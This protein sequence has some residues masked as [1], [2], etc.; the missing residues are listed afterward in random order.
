[1]LERQP[2]HDLLNVD[3]VE[4][5]TDLLITANKQTFFKFKNN[6]F[7]MRDGL[8]MG[9]PLAG[10]MSDVFIHNN[11][12]IELF[13]EKYKSINEHITF[14]YRYVDDIII[15]FSGTNA[16][17][18]ALHTILNNLSNLQFTLEKENNHNIQFLDLT[19]SRN[20]INN[21]LNF[22]IFRKPTHTDVIIPKSSFNS[23]QNK[24]ASFRFFFNRINNIPLSKQDYNTEILNIMNIGIKNGYSLKEM[25]KIYDKLHRKSINNV[26]YPHICEKPQF[27][28]LKFLGKISYDI[29]N[30]LHKYNVNVVFRTNTKLGALMSNTKQKHNRLGKSGIYKIACDDCNCFYIGQT[31]KNLE[32]RFKQ[33][34]KDRNSSVFKHLQQNKHT[35]NNNNIQLLHECCKSR[36]MNILED[37]EIIKHHREAPDLILNEHTT[38]NDRHLCIEMLG[39]A[40][41]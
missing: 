31:G 21:T 22:N 3:D 1:M 12:E 18:V 8:A 15:L 24:L 27:M 6:F 35:T 20:T 28:S 39:S 36:R 29:K 38:F 17:I 34:L 37:Y 16:H 7:H 26:I 41:R 19:I 4:N 32:T 5:L 33:H 14:Y 2:D 25:Q 11:I 23:N 40:A 30:T 9:S 10:V 13:S